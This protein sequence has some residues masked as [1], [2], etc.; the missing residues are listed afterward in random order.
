MCIVHYTKGEEI[1]DICPLAPILTYDSGHNFTK[2][3]VD[4]ENLKK[5]SYAL[6]IQKCS[7][8]T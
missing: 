3:P 5:H 6:K 2:H 1:Q 7:C 8:N 4:T